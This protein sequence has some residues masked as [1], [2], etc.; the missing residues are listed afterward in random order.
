VPQLAKYEKAQRDFFKAKRKELKPLFLL[1][2]EFF[3]LFDSFCKV[4][5][6]RKA[7]LTDDQEQAYNNCLRN[8]RRGFL[9][10]CLSIFG[11]DPLESYAHTRKAIESCLFGMEILSSA[12]S[13]TI[14]VKGF[15]SNS[16]K[17]RYTE[18]F[19]PMDLI[20]KHKALI[21]ARFKK[22]YEALCMSVHPSPLT[23]LQHS[24]FDLVDPSLTHY[25][26]Q[27]HTEQIVMEFFLAL[28]DFCDMLAC[29]Q[30]AYKQLFNQQPTQMFIKQIV[31]F[32]DKMNGEKSVW[33]TFL[34]S[35]KSVTKQSAERK[36]KRKR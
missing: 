24:V 26:E 25:N 19:R 3:K 6:Y 35:D 13:A 20:G 7:K 28:T 11:G 30:G 29:L 18:K 33:V 23:S 32:L 10:A 4:L 36:P 21:G 9:K 2:D 8:I 15:S 27:Q 1:A 14:F 17:H 12:Q 5:K 16:A 22:R 34:K 31:K